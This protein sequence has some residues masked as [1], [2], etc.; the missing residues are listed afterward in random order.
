VGYYLNSG[1]EDSN[2]FYQLIS[3]SEAD[4]VCTSISITSTPSINDGY[5][6][7]SGTDNLIQCTSGEC[8]DNPVN[9]EILAIIW[10][11]VLMLI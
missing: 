1:Y 8:I 5:Y 9:A 4:K 2:K 10:M 11:L 7:N 6:V 3:C